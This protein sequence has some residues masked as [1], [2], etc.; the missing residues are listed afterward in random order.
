M[1]KIE[2]AKLGDH[3]APLFKV[4]LAG[5]GFVVL[6]REVGE[7][8]MQV[9]V[10]KRVELLTRGTHAAAV[11]VGAVGA[12]QVACKRQGQPKVSAAVRPVEE[13]GMADA[14]F[15]GALDQ[16]RFDVVVADDVAK[17]HVAKVGKGRS[18]RCTQPQD[19]VATRR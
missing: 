14:V 3:F 8:K 11:G 16:T 4:V 15:L 5:G 19:E 9:W 13:L 18:E 1:S 7:G 2:V 12:R 17:Q 10:L 6:A